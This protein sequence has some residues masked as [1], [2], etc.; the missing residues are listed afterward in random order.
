MAGTHVLLGI[1][2]ILDVGGDLESCGSGDAGE[3]G[4]EAET[5]TA[6][7][8]GSSVSVTFMMQEIGW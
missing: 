2:H 6:D 8:G 5:C 7:A 3:S 1:D 4:C